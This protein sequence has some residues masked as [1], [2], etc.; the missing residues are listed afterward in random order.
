[1]PRNALITF[2]QVAKTADAMKSAGLKPTARAIRERLG[3]VGSMQTVLRHLQEWKTG[4]Q[5]QREPGQSLPESVQRAFLDYLDA[6]LTDA[7]STLA[8]ELADQRVETES[9]AEE[10]DRLVSALEEQAEAMDQLALEKASAE[11]Q[12]VQLRAE[13]NRLR[14][15]FTTTRQ[16]AE[17][18]R[19]ELAKVELRLEAV[20]RLEAD[21]ATN[22]QLYESERQARVA[23][24]QATAVLKSQK[25]DLESRL[26]ER[27]VPA[28]TT[29]NSARRSEKTTSS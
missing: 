10:N 16:N 4:Q 17:H 5:R 18:A 29:T 6:R 1:M 15:E 19:I 21:L 26:A 8:A 2:N 11:G 23:A 12:V 24:E 22:R 25:A 14:E 27:V 13:M 9:V 7:Q 3:N 20:L 28:H